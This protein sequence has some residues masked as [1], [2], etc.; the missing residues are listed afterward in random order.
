MNKRILIIIIAAVV[1]V[2]AAAA[3][4]LLSGGGGE[5]AYVNYTPGDEFITNAKES[6]KYIR[7]VVVLEVQEGKQEELTAKEAVIRDAIIFVLRNKTEAEFRDA[8]IEATLRTE[9]ITRLT[10]ALQLEESEYPIIKN[11]YFSDFVIS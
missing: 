1:V 8:S 10:E 6:S 11:V 3:F 4:L 7:V 2:G 5:P 9:I